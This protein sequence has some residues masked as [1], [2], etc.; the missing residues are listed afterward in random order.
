M[1][2]RRLIRIALLVGIGV[3][4]APLV[5]LAHSHLR[6]SE[7]KSRERLTAAPTAIR[8]WFSEPP[9]LAFTRIRVRGADSVDRALGPVVAISGEPLGVSA[10]LL[11][12]LAGGTYTVLW[13]TGGADGHPSRGHFEFV[14]LA[15]AA[16]P[17][18]KAADTPT[19]S[20]RDGHSLIRLDPT[21]E[22]PLRLNAYA[23]TRW[24]EFI[25]VLG[26]VGAIVFR[27]VVLAGFERRAAA[28]DAIGS[29]L[30]GMADGSRRFGQNA[31]L[32]LLFAAVVRLYGEAR[33]ML[34]PDRALDAAFLRTLLG[35]TSW[36]RGWLIGAAGLLVTALGFRWARRAR[37]GW[38]LAAV[39]AL[40]VALS[41]AL[42]GHA[43]VTPPVPLSLLD[44]V[45][46]IVA[47]SAWLG[48]LLVLVVAGLAAFRRPSSTGRTEDGAAVAA[49]LR[50]FHPVALTCATAAILTGV[51]S[52]WLR[53]PN[54]ASLWT[55]AY[56][57]T[58][59]LKVACV[60]V[61]AALGAYHWRR[62]LPSLGDDQSTRGV[63]R[64][65]TIE[66]VFAAI[67][68]GFTA[69]L[70]SLPTPDAQTPPPGETSAAAS[71]P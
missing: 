13:Q 38:S 9:Q 3:L 19:A 1:N 41:A 51:I 48:T 44:D 14:V 4:S 8:L 39:G 28:A 42:T 57:W 71:P 68:L 22:E 32:L 2:R 58:L 67:V 36:G 35:G 65:A 6:R 29:A 53:L 34:G 23:A 12:Q 61:V 59:L 40:A 69:L 64:S 43:A 18:T 33:V 37:A 16:M 60:A 62:A 31:L 21:A 66:L 5:L 20:P 45:I 46:H 10:A 63:R 25:A 70:V 30:S 54:V 15:E 49:L 27:L 17:M 50:G 11:A 7:P 24:L 26:I 55:S 52:A 47:A 56:G